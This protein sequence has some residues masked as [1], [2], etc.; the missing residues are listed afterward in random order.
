MKLIPLFV[1]LSLLS[2]G[3]AKKQYLVCVR[4]Q[5]NGACMRHQLSKKDAT[6]VGAALSGLGH[7][8]Y[9]QE[10]GKKGKAP[11]AA[12]PS[13]PPSDPPDQPTPL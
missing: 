12:P 2:L 8:V 1:F 13:A 7:N 4:L 11:T 10:I 5:E 6:E 3:C 9:I